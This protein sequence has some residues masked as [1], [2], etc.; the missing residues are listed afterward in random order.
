M[1]TLLLIADKAPSAAIGKTLYQLSK[2]EDITADAFL[3]KALYVAAGKHQGGFISSFLEEHPGFEPTSFTEQ[4]WKSLEADDSKL[5]KMILPTFI[6]DAGLDIDGEVWFRTK[7]QL[8]T[9]EASRPLE[10][11]LGP[12]DDTDETYVNGQKV[13]GMEGA[14][15]K[16]EFIQFQGRF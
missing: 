3:S 16:N 9:K 2:S 1:Q 14:W 6:E 4:N 11:H 13:G 8:T 15:N 12:I 7:F 10:L 5:E